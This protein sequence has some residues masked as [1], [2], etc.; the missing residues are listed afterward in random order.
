MSCE[1]FKTRLTDFALGAED[2]EFGAHL[3]GCASCR[4]ALDA[5]RSLRAS[6]DRGLAS[7]VAGKP[8]GDFA[9]HV[10]QRIAQAGVTTRPWFAGWMPVTA[11]ALA[12]VVLVGVLTIGRPPR[13]PQ[14]AEVK[15]PAQVAPTEKAGAV[16]P[17]EVTPTQPPHTVATG[18]RPPRG[19]QSAANREPEVLVPRGQMDAVMQLY[20]SIWS[21]KADGSTLM[22]QAAPIEELLKPLKTPELR[23]APLEIERLSEEGKPM[24]SSEKH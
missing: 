10:R 13:P 15:P 21:R 4:A 17:P 1:Q 22:A 19:P 9:A 7:L 20:N 12:L 3:D 24:G 18:R 23:I 14:T 11:A 6:I 2:I 8:S 5:Q 16:A